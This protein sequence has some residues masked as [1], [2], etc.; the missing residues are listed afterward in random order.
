MIG[1][2]APENCSALFCYL[3]AISEAHRVYGGLVWLRYDKQ[4]RQKKAIRPS[5]RWDH[6]DIC[7]W[8]KLMTLSKAISQ[9]FPGGA[10]GASSTGSPALK[11]KGVCW[12]FIEGICQFGSSCR[13]KHECL[14]CGGAHSLA[15]GKGRTGDAPGKR[16]DSGEAGKDAPFSK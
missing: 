16:D 14:W 13:Y 11:K 15:Q 8:M 2:K 6:K 12:Q 10:G 9:F 7:L 3:E 1:E 5:I 4:F